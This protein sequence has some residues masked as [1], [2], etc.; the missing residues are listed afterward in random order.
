MGWRQIAKAAVRS[1]GIVVEP[2]FGQR[3]PGM[4][5][6]AEKGLVQE[7]V[8]QAAV[9]TLDEGILLRLTWDD[10]V[11]LDAV[12]LRTSAGSLCW[13]AR[14]RCRRVGD[15]NSGLAA[16]GDNRGERGIRHK[17]Q[18]LAGEVVDDG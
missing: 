14:Y 3:R 12:L 17:R 7:L 2:P 1:N 16:T 18:A 8:A 15:A 10:V 5:H 13:S 6:R 9:E 11:P 4:D